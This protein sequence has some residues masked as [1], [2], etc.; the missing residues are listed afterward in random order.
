MA[1]PLLPSLPMLPMAI[2]IPLLPTEWLWGYRCCRWRVGDDVA[3]DGDGD[4]DCD[5]DDVAAD[6]E[7]AMAIAM[8]L[9][10]TALRWR[11]QCCRRRGGGD[12]D[13]ADGEFAMAWQWR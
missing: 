5:C 2:A 3:A 6:C 8:A 7:M 12:A 13:T 9:R 1:M 4:C 11:R 10:P